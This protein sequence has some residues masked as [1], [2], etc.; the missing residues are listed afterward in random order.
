MTGVD[1]VAS[2]RDR[3]VTRDFRSSAIL[4]AGTEEQFRDNLATTDVHL[5]LQY[6]DRLDALSR[7]GPS[8]APA[9]WEGFQLLHMTLQQTREPTIKAT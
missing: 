7:A 1:C 2:T 6:L 4:A 8:S 9:N 3:H 5:G